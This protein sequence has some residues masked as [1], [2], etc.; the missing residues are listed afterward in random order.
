MF[1]AQARDQFLQVVASASAVRGSDND[2][3]LKTKLLGFG[4]PSCFDGS[5]G[6]GQ[7]PV[8]RLSGD[9]EKMSGRAHHVK[10]DSI[11]RKGGSVWECDS[12]RHCD[13]DGR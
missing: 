7:S 3:R 4:G 6:I 9:Q 1:P 13:W 5:N 10:K 8:L 11:G 12:G 2:F